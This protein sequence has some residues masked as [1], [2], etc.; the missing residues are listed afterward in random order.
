MLL[1]LLG[2]GPTSHPITMRV[3]STQDPSMLGIIVFTI[4]LVVVTFAKPQLVIVDDQ[5]GD[6][7]T[8]VLPTFRAP[9]TGKVWN[10]GATC[11]YCAASRFDASNPLIM[12]GTWHDATGGSEG[13]Y[14]VD[15]LFTGEL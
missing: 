11:Q 3:S 7:V 6:M 2:S 10:Q 5:Y 4:S 1:G 8:G 9:V 13:L 14:S 15:V 12:N